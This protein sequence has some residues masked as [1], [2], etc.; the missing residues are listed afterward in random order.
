[1]FLIRTEHFKQFFLMSCLFLSLH[2]SGS[3]APNSEASKKNASLPKTEHLFPAKEADDV[4]FAF[5]YTQLIQTSFR[6]RA[7]VHQQGRDWR[8][9]TLSLDNELAARLEQGQTVYLRPGVK[10]DSKVMRSKILSLKAKTKVNNRVDLTITV[11]KLGSESILVKGDALELQ[12]VTSDITVPLGIE[13]TGV[14]DFNGEKGIISVDNGY[15]RFIPLQFG[16]EGDKYVQ[17]NSDLTVRTPY[18]NRNVDWVLTQYKT[19]YN[20]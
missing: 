1:M 6:A 10:G 9:L 3:E 2:C 11:T 18:V 13:K 8:E 4:R 17:V 12:F 16:I 15:Y 20:N 19:E 7:S 5:V 14:V